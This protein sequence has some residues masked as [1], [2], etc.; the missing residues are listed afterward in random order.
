MRLRSG[1]HLAAMVGAVLCPLAAAA[2]SEAASPTP[3]PEAPEKSWVA[4]YCSKCHETAWIGLA[5]GTESAWATRIRRMVRRGA[6]I[7]AER[8]A[9]LARYL[10]A[11]LPP[12]VLSSAI[13]TS[14]INT[15]VSRVELRPL[16]VWVRTAGRSG[17]APRSV[18]A[19]VRGDQAAIVRQGQRVR[20]FQL[21]SR[22]SMYQG[23][24]VAVELRDG[25]ATV[26][27]ALR[28]SGLETED[29]LLEIIADLGPQLS[30]PNEAVIEEGDRQL[31]YVRQATG[32]YVPREIRTGQ[33]GELFVEVAEGLKAG[34][35]VVT[36]GSFFIDAEFRMKGLA[37]P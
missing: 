14:P 29:Y 12:R 4:S 37:G 27:V 26:Q 13:A 18:V 33:R 1:L 34:E 32:D 17:P 3:L 9:P 30:I 25:L 15:T 16:Q 5:G 2:A 21:R 28:S 22:A 24:I 7:P 31:V 11:A 23:Q 6:V 35:E 10:A 20:A 19:Q 8:I 36:F